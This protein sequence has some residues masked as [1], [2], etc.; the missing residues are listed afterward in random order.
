MGNDTTAVVTVAKKTKERQ[1]V[2]IGESK[3]YITPWQDVV[4]TQK[5]SRLFRD[6]FAHYSLD[7]LQL[8]AHWL[9]SHKR[10][11]DHSIP[12]PYNAF[13]RSG[14][15]DLYNDGGLQQLL[16]DGML[17]R[18]DFSKENHECREYTAG[19]VLADLLTKEAFRIKIQRFLVSEDEKVVRFAD[20]RLAGHRNHRRQTMT[21]LN[22]Q[23]VNAMSPNLIN[24][25][26]LSA[27]Y[28]RFKAQVQQTEEPR[29]KKRLELKLAGIY[30][31]MLAIKRQKHWLYE[32]WDG[33]EVVSYLPGYKGSIGGRLYEI[34]G[35]M[36]SMPREFKRAA[37][38]GIS[39]LANYDIRSCHLAIIAQYCRQEGCPLSIL[40]DYVANPEA[41]KDWARRA[42]GSGDEKVSLW[43][44]C[45]ISLIYGAALGRCDKSALFKNI[46]YWY[47][48]HMV[49]YTKED[50]GRAYD[51]FYR[52][53][54]PFIEARKTWYRVLQE[55]I[56]PA[57]THRRYKGKGDLYLTNAC[58]A[59]VLLPDTMRDCELRTLSSFFCQGLESA[60]ICHLTLLSERYGFK[61]RSIEHDGLIVT[62]KYKP[63]YQIPERAIEEARQ[64]SGFSTAIL[65]E[66]VL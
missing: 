38:R 47:A 8:I 49:S 62:S 30:A 7:Q 41:K 16:D 33:D 20:G 40:E 5:F 66:K 15:R 39:N 64:Q 12:I 54:V 59:E 19:C 13:V 10:Y 3:A 52:V 60:F 53:A 18:T 50:I 48:D 21:T 43:K 55:Q 9:D 51:N 35:G 11:K 34:G 22:K 57:H 56:I 28:E 45:I 25:T 31:N 24:H 63:M 29:L 65:E 37:Y 23:A 1:A 46:V 61:V 2:S 6:Q 26:V 17:D 42:F 27:Q 4:S 14:L 36:Q 44:E 32:Q 58:G